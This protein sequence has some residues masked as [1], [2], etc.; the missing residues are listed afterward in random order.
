MAEYREA[1]RRAE[2][3]RGGLRQRQ[4]SDRQRTN[5]ENSHPQK[6]GCG[7]CKGNSE[8]PERLEL[9]RGNLHF[10]LT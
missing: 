8:C 2:W 7:L 4:G 9:V 5:G 10:G 6:A 1:L 3:G